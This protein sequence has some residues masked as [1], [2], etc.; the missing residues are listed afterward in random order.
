MAVNFDVRKRRIFK[1]KATAAIARLMVS[2]AYRQ[3]LQAPSC[4][5]D[6]PPGLVHRT[7]RYRDGREVKVKCHAKVMVGLLKA[8]RK[9]PG[10]EV[11]ASYDSPYSG[12]YRTWDQQNWLY[13]RYLNGGP[14]AASPCRGYHRQGR[15]LDLL[16]NTPAEDQ[17]MASVRVRDGLRHLKF[18]H[19]AAFGDPRH[20]TLGALG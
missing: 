15:A 3:P 10:I 11:T 4:E 9:E 2:K 14:R 12:S 16:N 8:M 5:P 18:Y 13:Q 6:D 1:L 19:G 7:F 20:W 17:A